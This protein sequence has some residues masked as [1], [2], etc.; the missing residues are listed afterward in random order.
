[1]SSPKSNQAKKIAPRPSSLNTDKQAFHQSPSSDVLSSTVVGEKKSLHIRSSTRH[2]SSDSS[3]PALS[4][5]PHS[6]RHR[7]P[8]MRVSIRRNQNRKNSRRTREKRRAKEDDLISM[9]KQNSERIR[10][11]ESQV[12]DLEATLEHKRDN[13][14]RKNECSSKRAHSNG[15]FFQ[16]EKFFGD[17][18]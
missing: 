3:K 16:E 5:L 15:E 11:L 4:E 6:V 13:R 7:S 17:A 1:M 18:F 2:V 8:E 14:R 12:K 10:T 9:E